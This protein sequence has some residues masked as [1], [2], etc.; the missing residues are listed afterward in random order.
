MQDFRRLRVWQAAHR[1]AL[2]VYQASTGFP[3]SEAYGLTSQIRRS[4]VSIGANVAEGCGRGPTADTR[5]CVQIALGSACETLN[6][7]LLARDL[8]LLD[9]ND[10]A[11]I[12][13]ELLPV[14][15]MLIRLIQ[16]LR[17]TPR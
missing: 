7:A 13:A 2:V 16:R 3:K 5:R 4:A 17:A 15:R 10:F 1:T 12:E 14:R 6:H 8:G 11:R 9:A